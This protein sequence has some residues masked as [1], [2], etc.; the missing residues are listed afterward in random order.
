[1]SLD[2]MPPIAM[3]DNRHR[4]DGLVFLTCD[5]CHK[6][7]RRADQVAG[8]LCRV[9]PDAKTRSAKLELRKIIRGI[10]NNAPEIALEWM[11]SARQRELA[12]RAGG[13]FADG[14]AGALNMGPKTNALMLRF[15]A[16]AALALHYHRCNEIVPMKGGAFVR[17]YTNESLITGNY[18]DDFASML[19]LPQSLQQSTKT[20]TGQFDYSSNATSEKDVSVHQ[21]TFR[22]SLS[23]QAWVAKDAK[24]FERVEKLRPEN[25]FRPGFLRRP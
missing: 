12:H 9:Y 24:V 2:H 25:L 10:R 15:A 5:D 6:G 19:P 14:G 1:M 17:W 3:F 4:P 7:T 13:A 16:R 22:L 11:P 20:Q 8:F 18:P 23:F 21:M